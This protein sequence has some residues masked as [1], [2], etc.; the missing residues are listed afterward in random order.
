[1]DSSSIYRLPVQCRT[2]THPIQ[3]LRMIELPQCTVCGKP[4]LYYCGGCVSKPAFCSTDHFMKVPSQWCCI[5]LFLLAK[6]RTLKYWPIHSQTCNRSI[7]A[8]GD[9]GG[10]NPSQHAFPYPRQLTLATRSA[11]DPLPP[12]SVNH[13]PPPIPTGEPY[14]YIVNALYA[15]HDAGTHHIVR[16]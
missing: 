13:M 5:G 11:V 10:S 1:M 4:T 9:P 15:K 2:P 7:T 6:I 3:C 16:C 12:F 8:N 14:D